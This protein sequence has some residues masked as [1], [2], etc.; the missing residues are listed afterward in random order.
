MTASQMQMMMQQ[1][2]IVR[3]LGIFPVIEKGCVL[4][5]WYVYWAVCISDGPPL[6]QTHPTSDPSRSLGHLWLR[7][8]TC[9]YIHS[10]S[11]HFHIHVLSW[12]QLNT[13]WVFKRNMHVPLWHHI[14]VFNCVWVYTLYKCFSLFPETCLLLSVTYSHNS[15]LIPMLGV[16]DETTSIH[17][18]T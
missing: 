3:K 7:P 13:P 16:G 11:R 6:H 8:A 2:G 17:P 12:N 5:P 18:V 9:T 4:D 1:F 15:G 14:V 10:N